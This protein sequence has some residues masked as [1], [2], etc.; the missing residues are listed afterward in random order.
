MLSTNQTLNDI[1][2]INNLILNPKEFANNLKSVKLA[3]QQ[4][5]EEYNELINNSVHNINKQIYLDVC[6]SIRSYAD[7]DKIQKDLKTHKLKKEYELELKNYTKSLSKDLLR[8]SNFN[9][10][11]FDDLYMSE[12]DEE[13]FKTMNKISSQL[14]FRNNFI[15]ENINNV[16]S[17][18]I[19][20]Y[21][22]KVLNYIKS[23]LLPKLYKFHLSYLKAKQE[24]IEDNIIVKLGNDTKEIINTKQ[25]EFLNHM[26]KKYL[27]C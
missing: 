3:N 26:V 5:T 23:D 14:Q 1:Q 2:T 15:M 10:D 17:K 21:K 22:A 16:S 27:G 24:K 25:Q 18:F 6:D 11:L 13:Y 19:S 4:L 7:V 9:D 20:D 12:T 8:N